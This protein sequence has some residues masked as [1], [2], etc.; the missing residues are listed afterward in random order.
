MFSLITAYLSYE[1]DRR[2]DRQADRAEL[3]SLIQHLTALP[4]ENFELVQKYKDEPGA[5]VQFSGF[6]LNE[7][8]ILT[9]QALGIIRRIPG[10]VSASEVLAVAAA[11]VESGRNRRRQE[12]DR[13]R[14]AGSQSQRIGHHHSVSHPR[15]L[16]VWKRPDRG[17]PDA[18]SKG[19]DAFA[20]RADQATPGFVNFT[21]TFTEMMWSQQEVGVRECDAAADHLR[22]A[23][24]L[25]RL[26]PTAFAPVGPQQLSKISAMID[27]CRQGTLY[28][29]QPAAP[30]AAVLPP[31]PQ[32][33]PTQ[34][35]ERQ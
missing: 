33:L 24:E 17:G 32:T 7:N 5:A 21:H 11:L 16:R 13:A 3:R 23:E 34:S 10:L 2:L 26:N 25:Y 12:P 15:R 20:D 27:P 19:R 35:S 14:R 29:V 1:R 30:P 22:R 8:L 31:S 9:N 4:R 28:D 18:I 6:I